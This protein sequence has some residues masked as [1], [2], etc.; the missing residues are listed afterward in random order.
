GGVVDLGVPLAPVDA[1]PGGHRDLVVCLLG[2]Q[3]AEVLVVADQAREGAA[4]GDVVGGE[5]AGERGEGR[6]AAGGAEG[7]GRAEAGGEER[8]GKNDLAHGRTSWSERAM[9][10]RGTKG[11][12]LARG[13]G[14]ED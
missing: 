1:E 12:P 9:T 4:G 2:P 13:G 6:R 3:H 8:Q 10:P 11:P 7:E 14:P 5:L